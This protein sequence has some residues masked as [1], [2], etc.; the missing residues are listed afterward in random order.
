LIAVRY[1]GKKRKWKDRPQIALFDDWSE[2]K[3]FRTQQRLGEKV[4]AMLKSA[5]VTQAL[6]EGW[7]LPTELFTCIHKYLTR[8][9]QKGLKREKSWLAQK[10]SCS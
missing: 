7:F 4:A 10:S 3:Y 5:G 9:E 1:F 8:A 2:S 6:F